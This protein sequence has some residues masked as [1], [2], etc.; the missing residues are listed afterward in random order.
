MKRRNFLATTLTGLL[1][2]NVLPLH[3]VEKKSNKHS[4][5]F[6]HLTDMHI[7]SGPVPERGIQNLLEEIH[8]LDEKPDF[9]INTGDNIMDSLKRSKEE[10]TEQWDSWREYYR[11]KLK[12]DL[13]SCIGNHD[14]WG[15]SLKNAEIETDPL[16]GKNWAVKELDIPHRYYSLDKKG[17]H[18]IFLDSSFRDTENHS[19][20]AKL[21]KEQFEWLE[22]DLKNTPAKTPICV[23]SHI[24]IISTSVFF[25]GDNEKSGGWNVPGAWMHIDA[26][27]IKDLFAD[28]P[29][30]KLAIS[31]HVHLADKT[32]YLGIDYL[33]NGAAC[34]AWWQGKYQE[35]PPMYAIIDLYEDGSFHSQ[36]V[37]YNWKQRSINT[38]P[39]ANSKLNDNNTTAK[40]D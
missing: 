4:L 6:V 32:N 20:T 37:H 10:T 3:A 12:Y 35:F 26:R 31:G 25:D 21:D 29:N 38:S 7:H 30:I 8:T 34:G 15:W 40:I 9:V 18:F 22:N 5:R 19:Y 11:S 14:I 23:V 1:G 16:F 2:A 24:P 36:L 13:F 33:C 17:W 27:K 28:F 39:E